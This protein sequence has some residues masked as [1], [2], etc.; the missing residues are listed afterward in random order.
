MKVWAPGARLE[1]EP[2][3]EAEALATSSSRPASRSLL[4]PRPRIQ[5]SEELRLLLRA[6]PAT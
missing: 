2:E 3:S 6:H 1:L 4:E 5:T